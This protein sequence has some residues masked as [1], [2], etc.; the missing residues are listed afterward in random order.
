[1][2]PRGQLRIAVALVGMSASCFEDAPPLGSGTSE[3]TSGD[4]GLTS[5]ETGAGTTS[6]TATA[7]EADSVAA[8]TSTADTA[9][10]S[11]STTSTAACGNG[12]VETDEMCDGT[13]G[14]AA[15][16]SFTS[17]ACN[18]LNGAGCISPQRCGLVDF[19]AETFACMRPG[20]AGVGGACAGDP[21]NDAECD[22][23][24]TCL[25]HPQTVLCDSGNCC[26]RYCDVTE[27]VSGCADFEQC[28][29]FFPDPMFEGLEHLGFCYS[30]RA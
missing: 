7:D 19:V 15:D 30:T 1:L 28:A 4:D 21:V 6:S 3:G 22:A 5:T 12:I 14:C 17:Y 11:S 29:P 23:E 10:E 20:P 25:F 9:P 26:V 13:P 8:D 18:P 2:R 24:L 27:G 16:C